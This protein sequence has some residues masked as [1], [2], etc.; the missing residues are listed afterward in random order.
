MAAFKLAFACLS[1]GLAGCAGLL[2]EPRQYYWQ[3]EWN[4]LKKWDWKTSANKTM[5]VYQQPKALQAC[6][7][8]PLEKRT[9]TQNGVNDSV[10]SIQCW[11]APYYT[12]GARLAN[13]P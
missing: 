1:L 9:T 8:L 10:T 4:Q 3:Q 11:Q 7:E 2:D 6:A 5:G 12:S 13:R